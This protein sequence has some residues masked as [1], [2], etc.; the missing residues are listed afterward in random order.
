MNHWDK[1]KIT[2]VSEAYLAIF[3]SLEF[4]LCRHMQKVKIEKYEKRTPKTFLEQQTWALEGRV[5][6]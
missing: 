2:R 1:L 4:P 6:D 3:V 5:H